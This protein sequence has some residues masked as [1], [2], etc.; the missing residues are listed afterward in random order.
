MKSASEEARQ[1]LTALRDSGLSYREIEEGI[2]SRVCHRTLRR[3]HDG[4]SEP[5]QTSHVTALY[6][7]AEQKGLLRKKNQ[8][9]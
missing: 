2:D 6:T 9:E 7:F 3:W 8:P 5:N 4:S 1:L